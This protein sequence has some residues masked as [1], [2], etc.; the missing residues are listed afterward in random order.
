MAGWLV[1]GTEQ[2]WSRAAV[3]VCVLSAALVPAATGAQTDS[4]R[5]QGTAAKSSARPAVELYGRIIADYIY[6]FNQN[7]PRW[8]DVVRPSKLPAFE[9]EFG[10]DGRM[11]FSVRQTFF[12]VRP[13]WSSPLGEVRGVFQFDLF[14]D[15]TGRTGLDLVKAYAELG[16][17][18]AGQ[19]DSPFMDIDVFPNILEYWG[20]ASILFFRNIQFRYM[21]IQGRSRVT[22]ALERG[23]ASGD[24][25]DFDDHLELDNIIGRYP[26]P[27]LS[28]EGRLGRAWGYVELAGI[29]RGIY[30][31]DNRFPN[32]RLD[33]DGR[34]LGWGLSL[35]SNVKTTQRDVLKFQVFYGE[36]I[37]SYSGAPFDIGIRVDPFD[38]IRPFEGAALPLF[39]ALAF[40]DHFWSDKFS[41]SL[42]Y[43]RLDVHNS[44]GQ[45]LLAFGA[46][47][48]ALINLLYNP[49]E[50]VQV[51]GEFQWARRQNAF[52]D[53]E[54]H[55]FRLQFSARYRWSYTIGRDL[56]ADGGK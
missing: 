44:D 35:S 5:A 43:S 10:R 45:S 2:T 17:F 33:L 42:G 7:D 50:N 25:G 34:A 40:Y 19:F 24:R 41:T 29:L 27:T 8:F 52:D 18:G 16:K 55:D 28:A 11:H 51:G 31:D 54:S 39:G 6:D 32:D 53:F 4:T 48:Y 12:G 36:A 3:L 13:Q 30:W 14:G 49:A 23:A 47:D 15:G 9:D 56:A 46:G 37:S 26:W 20:P 38:D 1:R 21:P 22:V